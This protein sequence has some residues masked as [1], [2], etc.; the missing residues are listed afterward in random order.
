MQVG[1]PFGI[2]NRCREEGRHIVTNRCVLSAFRLVEPGDLVSRHGAKPVAKPSTTRLVLKG[3]DRPRH[4][5]QDLLND[6]IGVGW[7]KSPVAAVTPDDWAVNFRKLA[8]RRRVLRISYTKQQAWLC[9]AR[10]QFRDVPLIYIQ[11]N[12]RSDSILSD[13][14]DLI[15]QEGLS[16][17]ERQVSLP[18]TEAPSLL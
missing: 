2:L 18:R 13:P 5:R 10:V 12:G 4:L 16:E 9:G 11:K 6:V 3:A 7:L 8:P 14:L 15:N 17:R 1:R